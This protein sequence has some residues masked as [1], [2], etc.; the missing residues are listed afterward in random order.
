MVLVVFCI[1]FVVNI[2]VVLKALSLQQAAE[3]TATGGAP[4]D[5]LATLRAEVAAMRADL[6]RLD[7][8][9]VGGV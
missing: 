8:G 3:S 9:V 2:V 7:R 6:A 1:W 5:E 4:V